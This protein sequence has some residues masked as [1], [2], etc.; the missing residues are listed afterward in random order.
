VGEDEIDDFTNT[1]PL[2]LN[3]ILNQ[4]KTHYASNDDDKKTP[5]YTPLLSQTT[6]AMKAN[7]TTRKPKTDL[8]KMHMRGIMSQMTQKVSIII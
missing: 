7:T 5:A 2:N 1:R 4:F 3:S 6:V 8:D